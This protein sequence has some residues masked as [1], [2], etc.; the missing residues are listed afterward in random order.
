M[1]FKVLHGSHSKELFPISEIKR[2]AYFTNN[3]N[4]AKYFTRGTG[5]VMPA[6]VEMNHPYI[7]DWQGYSWGGGLY[8]EDTALFEE[9]LE[10]AAGDDPEEREY[11][12][13]CG[14]CLDMFSSFIAEKGIYDGMVASNVMEECDCYA[15]V[16]IAFKNTRISPVGKND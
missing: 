3:K 9:Y 1:L 4:V 16:Y 13:D 6:I 14:L 8:P 5:T 12:N 11:W 7:I 15:T 10:F 2:K